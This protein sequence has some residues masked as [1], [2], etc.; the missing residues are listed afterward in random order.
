MIGTR[1]PEG[2]P[3]RRRSVRA[4]AATVGLCTLLPGTV[5]AIPQSAAAQPASGSDVTVEQ[6]VEQEVAADGAADFWVVFDE[7]ADLD[8]AADISDWGERGAYV[9]EK[10][11]AT[12]AVS[13]QA[14]TAEL[15]ADGVAY[16]PFW[17]AN[18]VLVRGGDQ[19][20]LNT[21]TTQDNVAKVVAHR[22]HQLPEPRP[23]QEPSASVDGVE[24]GIANIGADRVWSQFGTRGEGVVVGNIDTGVEYT[25]PALAGQYRG[26]TGDG[27]V[28]HDYSWWD[29]S[30]VCSG[31]APCDNNGHGSHTMGTMVGS[32]GANQVGVA[33]GARWI[34][35]KGCESN[36]CSQFALLSSAEFMLAPT[37]RAGNNPRPE[38]RPQIVNNSWGGGGSDPWY[39]A[40][41]DAWV[42]AGMFPVF[43]NGNSGSRCDSAGSPGDASGAYAVG[44][45]DANN[46]IAAF[47]SRGPGRGEE[48]RPN[49]S[50]PG[51][52]VRS[53]W[54]GGYHSISGTSMAAP[55]VAGA[56]A[57]L[58]SAAPTLEGDQAATRGLLDGTA[59]DV[60]DLQCGGTAAD[61][62]VWGEGRMD[63]FGA[64]ADSPMGS[65]GS[66]TGHITNTDG[67]PI[68]GASIEVVVNG[69]TRVMASG[70]DGGYTARL[71]VGTHELTVSAT[72]FRAVTETVE[73]TED[74]ATS[75]D[76]TLAPLPRIV[77]TVTDANDA[78]PVTGATITATNADGT[79]ETGA[80]DANGAYRVFLELGAW[81]VTVAAEGYAPETVEVSFG[82]DGQ[83]ET[84][85]VALRTGVATS[86]PAGVETT[87]EMFAKQTVSVELS[88]TGTA[89]LNWAILERGGGPVAGEWTWTQRPSEATAVQ[90]QA[91]DSAGKPGTQKAYPSAGQWTPDEVSPDQPRIAVYADDAFHKSPNTH[92]D[93]ALQRMG[94]AYTAFYDANYSGFEYALNHAEWDVVIFSN[95]N[96]KPWD[97]TL[98][99]L[100][101]HVTGGGKLVIASAWLGHHD[102]S[103]PLWKAVGVQW[104]RA[105]LHPV[106]PSPVHWWDELYPAFTAP[107]VVPEFTELTGTRYGNYGSYVQP[108]DGYTAVAGYT[109]TPAV[110]NA[111]M[112]VGND[113]RTVFKGFSDG[114]N[115]ADRN[116]NQIPDGVELWTNLVS[117]VG[118]GFAVEVPWLTVTPGDGGTLTPGSSQD[119]EVTIDTT[120]LKPGRYTA[121]ALLDTNAARQ[122]LV[123]IP[124]NLEITEV[125]YDQ[126]RTRVNTYHDNGHITDTGATQLIR[127]ANEAERAANRGDT[128]RA[129]EFLEQFHKIAT[130]HRYVT[131]K[132]ARE[133]L[134]GLTDQLTTQLR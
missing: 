77:G 20:V 39:D 43:S 85:N 72:G 91:L 132:T 125:T 93:Q 110:N 52:N 100:H 13:Q 62:N 97:P 103:H 127:M 76:F 64:V 61:N 80:V 87:M 123:H 10:L 104:V 124:I 42:A 31:G 22:S 94:L 99:L 9:Y 17:I 50:A 102:P 83:A 134:A 14:F 49:V 54:P 109:D 12:A 105:D 75:R 74:Q 19:Q 65:T 15:V 40:M 101:D 106:G 6:A 2:R 131:D 55:H 114:H 92:V 32:D 86:T 113:N 63:V 108:L 35:A 115:D 128:T 81:T 29:P 41:V 37:D 119:L 48:I 28:D 21:A 51:V 88:N 38:L 96:Y 69:R 27:A 7:S 24:W 78:L 3:R 11:T 120:G 89:D 16:E 118:D 66:V 44:A 26:N 71:P 121:A 58:W 126:L 53:S 46:A 57:L 60:E 95:D 25:H 4:V 84:R 82:Q 1:A 8:G 59:I 112:V 111:A 30:G 79:T 5:A 98:D 18:A 130:N 133:V 122:R 36:S 107:Q 73:V 34:A 33:P 90:Q 116:T 117:G 45:Y 56:A 68:S 47:S 129:I 70:S 67:A 23:A